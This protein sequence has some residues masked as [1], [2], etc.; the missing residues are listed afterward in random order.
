[1]WLLCCVGWGWGGGACAAADLVQMA[2]CRRRA[3]LQPPASHIEGVGD[4]LA[5]GS[6]QRP[7]GKLSE[8]PQVL[9]LLHACTEASRAGGRGQ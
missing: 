3:H 1:M 8:H 4:S 7:T 2:A 5:G 9:L 6:S